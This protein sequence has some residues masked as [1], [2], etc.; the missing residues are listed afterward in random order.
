[1]AEWSRSNFVDVEFFA[2]TSYEELAGAEPVTEAV[3]SFDH[4]DTLLKF[5][6]DICT[7][8]QQL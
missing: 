6:F 1:M 5:V 4:I 3:K 2:K 8:I 7:N